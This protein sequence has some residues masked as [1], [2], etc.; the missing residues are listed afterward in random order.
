MQVEGIQ[1]PWAGSAKA[2]LDSDKKPLMKGLGP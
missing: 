2:P 1:G